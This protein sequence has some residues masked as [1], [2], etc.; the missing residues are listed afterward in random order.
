MSNLVTFLKGGVH[1]LDFKS[2]T[3]GIPIRNAPIPALA[4][5]PMQQHMG[6]PAAGNQW[7]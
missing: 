7:R 1:P 2:F 5:I 6:K 3:S 4:V